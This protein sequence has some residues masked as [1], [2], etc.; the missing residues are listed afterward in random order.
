MH[1]IL[2]PRQQD[3]GS[4]GAHHQSCP[5]IRSPM[6]SQ[7]KPGPGNG[8][9]INHSNPS[10]S[11]APDEGHETDTRGNGYVTRW[12]GTVGMSSQNPFSLFS[13]TKPSLLHSDFRS[14]SADQR[15]ACCAD[16]ARHNSCEQDR[17]PST[18]Q[19]LT[20]SDSEPENQTEN[21]RQQ[22][23]PI[24]RTADDQSNGRPVF[25]T[26]EYPLGS[27][28][29]IPPKENAQDRQAHQ[30]RPEP[31]ESQAVS[32]PSLRIG[33]RDHF[34]RTG[35]I[36]IVHGEHSNSLIQITHHRQ[37][38]NR[39]KTTLSL[40]LQESDR[41]ARRNTTLRLSDPSPFCQPC[42]RW[43]CPASRRAIQII[44]L[45]GPGFSS[46]WGPFF[47]S[48]PGPVSCR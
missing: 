20:P 8:Q 36:Q 35:Q 10:S 17:H 31:P 47:A 16:E 4:Q 22:N 27:Q 2:K 24:G 11:T 6:G 23:N 30:H 9:G 45:H 41:S 26:H 3:G 19:L 5:N 13:G 28:P 29:I 33:S 46:W 48:V 38:T 15:T 40:S 42:D 12:E 21:R 32:E 44:C 14:R 18:G 7:V 34:T 43:M 25:T 1:P 37:A 39:K